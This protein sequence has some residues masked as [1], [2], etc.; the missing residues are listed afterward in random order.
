MDD[1]WP[2]RT[3]ATRLIELEGTEPVTPMMYLV[4]ILTV[5][6]SFSVSPLTGYAASPAGELKLS[7]VF[8]NHAVLQ[9][10]MPVPVW[11]WA[12]PGVEVQVS[13]GGRT[14]SCA[15]DKEGKW[16][17][18]F[19]AMP[20]GGPYELVVTGKETIRLTDILVG[21][22][23]ICAGQSNMEMHL[24]PGPDAVCNAE[25]EVAEADFPNIRLFTVPRRTSFDP[26][27][28]IHGDGWEVCQPESV[29]DFSAVGYFFGRDLHRH[30]DVPIGL[31]N[32]TWGASPAEAW[33]SA[34]ALRPLPTFTRL[35]EELPEK[36]AVS[37]AMLPDYQRDIAAWNALLE[38]RDAG[39]V[40]GRP[41]WAACDLDT[42][43]WG[44]MN[45]PDYW[46]S[47]GFPDFDGVMWYRKEV[48][49]PSL[50]QGQPL[51]LGLC[52]INDMD[53][54]YVNGIEVGRFE[55]AAGWTAP[56]IYPVP[57]EQVKPGTNVIAVRVFDIGNKGGI[58]GS[59]DDLWI[60]L[61]SG[62]TENS[63]S[64]AGPWRFKP[65]IDL[66]DLPPKPTPPPLLE[67]NQR[68]P[69]VLFNAMVAPLIPFSIRGAIWYQGE[70]NVGKAVA[71][72]TLFPAMIED[73]RS[74]WGQG[75]FPF[76]FVQLAAVGPVNTE[77]TDDPMP[78]LREAQ[79]AA[80]ALPNTAMTVTLDISDPPIGHPRNKQDVGKRLALAARRVAYGEDIVAWGPI[81]RDMRIENNAIRI[82][83]DS[84]GGGLK[85]TD[86]ESPK[87]FAIAGSDRTFVWA[88]TR[89]ENDTV[90]VSGSTIT[91]PVAVR[92]AWSNNPPANFCNAEGFPVSPFRT[93]S[94]PI[95]GQ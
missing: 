68:V 59:P 24:R 46:E 13:L 34:D 64:L 84:I 10:D 17:V 48:D 36:V 74:R 44:T 32:C 63:I 54:A 27:S 26:L 47:A 20:A 82:R 73:W 49:I 30:L 78:A 14:L 94:W 35:I 92:Y 95:Q 61:V 39:Q 31:I 40:D 55:E 1:L 29:I 90:V 38:S 23:W 76:L 88:D 69:S 28:D 16:R 56:R 87:G 93:D 60:R 6:L 53:R 9:R 37:R 81:Y 83:F 89:I 77:P 5:L 8:G 86:G 12:N 75:L 50:W 65:G 70:S 57:A 19:S 72:R 7:G 67:G 41:A 2:V 62:D 22:V 25:Q 15:A 71:Y 18:D 42:R 3:T 85:T 91:R 33:T 52:T 79:C 21:D 80:L 66:K 43:D 58:C 4:F 11:G 45:V 51:R